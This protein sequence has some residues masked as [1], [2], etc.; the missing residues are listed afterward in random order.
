MAHMEYWMRAT[1]VAVSISETNRTEQ[2]QIVVCTHKQLTILTLSAHFFEFFFSLLPLCYADTQTHW[3]PVIHV[4]FYVLC[5]VPKRMPIR[6]HKERKWRFSVALES[7]EIKKLIVYLYTFVCWHF[8]HSARWH[9]IAMQWVVWGQK[10]N[11]LIDR[12]HVSSW[13][14]ECDCV[15]RTSDIWKTKN[16]WH[17]WPIII[18]SILCCANDSTQV[19]PRGQLFA[20]TTQRKGNRHNWQYFLFR[21]CHSDRR[22]NCCCRPRKNGKRKKNSLLR[23]KDAA[24]E[25]LQFNSILESLDSLRTQK[26]RN[27]CTTFRVFAAQSIKSFVIR[28]LLRSFWLNEGSNICTGSKSEILFTNK[29]QVPKHTYAG[30]KQRARI[31]CFFCCWVV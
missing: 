7:P 10:I 12:I 30:R 27:I 28:S 5:S 24:K 25:F 31:K 11:N 21:W 18:F 16:C 8:T 13:V 26:G 19:F 20:E 3:S 14:H 6:V 9:M 15:R 23:L 17:R 4:F 29:K 1:A 22:A 2:Y